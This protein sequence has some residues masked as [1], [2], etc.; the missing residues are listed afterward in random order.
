M[1]RVEL[2]ACLRRAARDLGPPEWCLR[3]GARRL[4]SPRIIVWF[5]C[6]AA[7][8]VAAKLAVDRWGSRVEVVYCDT[9]WNEH[10]DSVRFRADVER[11][12]GSPVVTVR[13]EA[14]PSGLVEE[15][16]ARARYMS[17]VAGARCT[18]ELKKR[19][20]FAYQRP[21][22]IHVFG[23]TADE[24]RR[25]QVFEQ[26]NPELHLKWVLRDARL[27]KADCLRAVEAAGIR[28]PEMYRLGFKN[29]NCKGCVKARS[30]AY[31]NLTR[32]HF[33]DVF[34]RRAEQSRALGVRLARVKGELVFL[35]Q[36]P[37]ESAEDLGE[38]LSCG[39]QCS[40]SSEHATKS[41]HR[42]VV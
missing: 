27:S 28:L 41:T 23:M 11:W 30:P 3:R 17:G 31:W 29:N 21:D 10:E 4:L 13:S 33:P 36:L 26:G 18:V 32:K 37:P 22:D 2:D 40:T 7:S 34:R 39:P 42:S 38:D 20:R 9:S 25:I 24:G 14:Y 6:G 19:P 16:F 12:V 35:D 15:V 1:W 5:S 8:A